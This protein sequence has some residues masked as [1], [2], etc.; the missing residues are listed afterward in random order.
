MAFN[1][2]D[3]RNPQCK[4]Y[5]DGSQLK[6]STYYIE[7]VNVQI[8]GSARSNSCDVTVLADYDYKNSCIADG[9]LNKITA[10]KKVKIEMGYKIPKVVFMGYINAVSVSFSE[11]G[12]EVSFS[13][14]DARGLLMGNVTWQTYEN[15]SVS[16]IINKILNPLRSY[17]GG[18]EVSVPGQADKENPLSQN[19]LDD[20]QY[21]CQLATLTGSSFCMPDTKLKFVKN[22]YKTGTKQAEYKWGRDLISFE[23]NVELA[24]QLG[25]VKVTG[26]APEN[27]KSFSATAKPPSGGKTGAQLN[28]MVKEKS[29]DI[30]SY[31]VKDQNE[32]KIYAQSLMDQAAMKLCTGRAKVLGNEKLT[33]GG[34]VKFSGL[35]PK[36]NGEYHI[37]ALSHS[38]SPGGFLT[39]ISFAK[40]TV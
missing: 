6:S 17:T 2:D 29:R 27:I 20:Y 10:G 22:I 33:P 5:V 38:F 24:D 11:G 25:S 31:A 32:A 23:R 1:A 40:P 30:T 15:E 28:S 18:I 9:L 37:V 26:N 14:L 8:S 3:Y 34:K 16:Q 12:V 13:C 21:I 7:A 35:D 39:M 4:V 36:L 19:D